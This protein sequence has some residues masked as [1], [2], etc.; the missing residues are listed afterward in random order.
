[1]L[2]TNIIK[3]TYIEPCLLKFSGKKSENSY[4]CYF[5]R[6]E[7]IAPFKSSYVFT[8]CN[9]VKSKSI[10]TV[11]LPEKLNELHVCQWCIYINGKL[12]ELIYG[13]YSLRIIHTSTNIQVSIASCIKYHRYFH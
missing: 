4:F 8:E 5:Q 11:G 9:T 7:L 10:D 1:M 2:V 6:F 12:F 13:V 3:L